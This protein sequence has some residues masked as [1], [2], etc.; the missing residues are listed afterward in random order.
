MK[1]KIRCEVDSS[2]YFTA[3]NPAHQICTGAVQAMFCVQKPINVSTVQE[4]V[5]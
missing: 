4:T 5:S 2:A 1:K 3:L